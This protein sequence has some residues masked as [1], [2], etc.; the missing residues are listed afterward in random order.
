MNFCESRYIDMC[1]IESA[2]RSNQNEFV[3]L[4]LN[5]QSIKVKFDNFFAIINRLSSLWIFLGAICQEIDISSWIII[6]RIF[7]HFPC[8]VN[9]RTPGEGR[10]QLKNDLHQNN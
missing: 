2:F 7:D 3:V 10:K 8:I 6:S 9:F 4:S 5:I 1:D